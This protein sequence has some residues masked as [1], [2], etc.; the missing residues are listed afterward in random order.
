MKELVIRNLRDALAGASQV[1][2]EALPRVL[3]M[4][5]IVMVGW[6]VAWMIEVAL[7]RL[8]VLARFNRLFESKGV[9]RALSGAALPSPA[10]MIGRIVFWL[11]WVSFILVGVNALGIVG[12][13]REVS[14]FVSLLP[15]LVVAF[16]I[17]FFGVLAANFL[18]RA[19]LLAAVN[20]NSPS[21]RL[22]SGFV[23]FLVLLLAL[24]M[25]VERIG[26]GRGVVLVAFAVI[27]GAIMLGLAI[28][29]GFGGRHVARHILERHFADGSSERKEE[30]RD[31]ET[32]HL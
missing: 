2:V 24:T 25:A 12:L 3:A 13:Q 11:I 28:A 19:A 15:Q 6:L 7:R 27:L 26:L 9:T 22:L 16:L 8:L 20:A 30:A 1:M 4:A 14:D 31:D 32:S 18:S 23:R 29:F 10:E 17:I 21:P 5:I